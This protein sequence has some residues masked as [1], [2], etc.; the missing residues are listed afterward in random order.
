MKNIRFFVFAYFQWSDLNRHSYFHCWLW[1]S[2]YPSP[3]EG[4]CRQE[5]Q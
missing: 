5:T 4:C 3:S 2:C 1:C